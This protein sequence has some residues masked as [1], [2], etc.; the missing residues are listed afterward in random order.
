MKK[1]SFIK[2]FEKSNPKLFELFKL[3]VAISC[4]AGIFAPAYMYGSPTNMKPNN[5]H[6]QRQIDSLNKLKE[7]KIKNPELYRVL[8]NKHDVNISYCIE[9]LEG[10]DLK[11][12]KYYECKKIGNNIESDLKRIK[13]II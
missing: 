12:D 13:E 4:L 7:I 8:Q 5:I 6:S 10:L 1:N 2:R 9:I 3:L 11:N